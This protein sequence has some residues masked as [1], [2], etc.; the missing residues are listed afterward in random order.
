MRLDLLLQVKLNI[1]LSFKIIHLKLPNCLISLIE[2]IKRSVT[3]NQAA[4]YHYFTLIWFIS[5]FDLLQNFRH[6]K[7]I[8]IFVILKR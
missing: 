4:S 6:F 1:P 7:M 2:T 5:W 3:V 8:K